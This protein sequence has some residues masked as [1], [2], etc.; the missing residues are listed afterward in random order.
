VT[1]E[2]AARAVVDATGQNAFLARRFG[3]QSTD[4]MLRHAAYFT[5]YRGARRAEGRD[6]GATLILHTKGGDSWFWFIPLPDDVVSIGVVGHIDHLLRGRSADPQQV[7]DEELARCP[8]LVPR[9]ASARQTEPVQALRDFSYSSRRIAGDGWVLVG[10]AF[11]FLDPIY[12]SGVFLALKGAEFTADSI[13]AALTAGELTAGR[14][15]AH[16]PTFLAGMEALRRLVYAYYDR[17]F[18]FARFVEAHPGARQ[19]LV[20]LLIG[21]VYRRPCTSVLEAMSPTV[22][23]DDYEPLALAADPA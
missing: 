11:G 13:H 20:S 17:E 21:N 23:P 2:L 6:A 14:L 12:S 3:L 15:G 18:S 4:P 5:R 8:A 19:D 16:G 1:R 7:Y 22:L 9:L 10:D